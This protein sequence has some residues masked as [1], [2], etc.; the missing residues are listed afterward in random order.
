MADKLITQNK[1]LPDE[2]TQDK[3]AQCVA[4]EGPDY[5]HEVVKVNGK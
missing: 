1:G 3:V 5:L 2:D 4:E